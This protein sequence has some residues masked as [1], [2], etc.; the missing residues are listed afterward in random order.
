MGAGSPVGGS[1]DNRQQRQQALQRPARPGQR[2]LCSFEEFSPTL[3]V[4]DVNSLN[5]CSSSHRR[6]ALDKGQ[7]P[8]R[9]AVEKM[10]TCGAQY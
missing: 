7:D 6:G 5:A 8:F 3:T 2:S 1:M 4:D 10:L 9:D